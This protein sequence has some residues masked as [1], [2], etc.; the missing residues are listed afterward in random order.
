M[1]KNR[2]VYV[3]IDGTRDVVVI[4]I[5]GMTRLATAAA[6]EQAMLFLLDKHLSNLGCAT[7]KDGVC[8]KSIEN[9]NSERIL[10]FSKDLEDNNSGIKTPRTSISMV[11]RDSKGG[12]HRI[13][14]KITTIDSVEAAA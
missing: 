14:T 11:R 1:S 7:V 6:I 2:K 13:T 5:K 4:N 8:F 3:R 9:L 10:R 12:F